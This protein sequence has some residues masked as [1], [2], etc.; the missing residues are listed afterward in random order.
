LGK[1]RKGANCDD[2]LVRKKE[3]E[4]KNEAGIIHGSHKNLHL[5]KKKRVSTTDADEGRSHSGEK[6]KTG[7]MVKKPKKKQKKTNRIS[8][9]LESST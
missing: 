7:A 3:K 1:E 8:R 9:N 4:A 2:L 5:T 6:K